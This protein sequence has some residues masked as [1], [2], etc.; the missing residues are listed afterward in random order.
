MNRLTFAAGAMDD[1]SVPRFCDNGD[2]AGR[3]CTAVV[4]RCSERDSIFNARALTSG[5]LGPSNIA[6]VWAVGRFGT[7]GAID[8]NNGAGTSTRP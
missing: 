7:W 5:G 6:R 8:K 1:D 4:G 3:P 2:L